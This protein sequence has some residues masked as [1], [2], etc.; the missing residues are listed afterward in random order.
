MGC[1]RT[2]RMGPARSPFKGVIRG[3]WAD[4]FADSLPPLPPPESPAP[5]VA[6]ASESPTETQKEDP[7]SAPENVEKEDLPLE[8]PE[9]EVVVKEES[10]PL[11]LVLAP[12]S[13]EAREKLGEFLGD[14]SE[15]S[16]LDLE[17]PEEPTK[18][19]QSLILF[20]E[21]SNK[22]ADLS[23]SEM[24]AFEE[25]KHLIKQEQQKETEELSI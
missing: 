17:D 6:A 12:E 9:P 1:Y 15:K 7:P 5:A 25:L 4:T 2:Q 21:E 16:K 22:V 23:D 10:I 20:K 3:L 11:P 8:P 14:D 13:K 18:I 19:P 24:K